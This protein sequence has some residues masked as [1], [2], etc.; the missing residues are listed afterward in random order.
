MEM[1]KVTR[2]QIL[3]T[4]YSSAATSGTVAVVQKQEETVQLGFVEMAWD[5]F[6]F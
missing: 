5:K 3:S 4:L 2:V 6:S 1:G